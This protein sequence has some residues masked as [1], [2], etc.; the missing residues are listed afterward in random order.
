M[1][2]MFMLVLLL[3]VS[4]KAMEAVPYPYATHAECVSA[5]KAT[6]A[7][8]Q[9]ASHSDYLGFAC[10]PIRASHAP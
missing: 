1:T 10:V 4:G 9:M 7:S 3:T 6:K 5:G 2:E 8:A